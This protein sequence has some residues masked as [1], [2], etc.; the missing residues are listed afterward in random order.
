ML[1]P[2]AAGAPN[3]AHTSPRTVC[4]YIPQNGAPFT[5]GHRAIST[6]LIPPAPKTGPPNVTSNNALRLVKYITITSHHRL[7]AFE[8]YT[9]ISSSRSIYTYRSGRIKITI[10][11]IYR[12][13]NIRRMYEILVLDLPVF[14][15]TASLSNT[16]THCIMSNEKASAS[17][18]G[19]DLLRHSPDTM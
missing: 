8:R 18:N 6:H 19:T 12:Y 10:R 2:P 16:H 3:A 15:A 13:I 5:P 14:I 4:E 17:N 7:F 11:S 9:C 1:S